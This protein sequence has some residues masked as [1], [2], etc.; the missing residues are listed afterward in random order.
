[1]PEVPDTIQEMEQILPGGSSPDLRLNLQ[2]STLH[3]ELNRPH[4]GN[5]LRSVDCARL[6]TLI[7]HLGTAEV[8]S[9]RAVLLSGEGRHFCTGGDLE[10]AGA[11]SSPRIGHLQRSLRRGAA[12]LVQSLWDCPLPVVAAVN[13]RAMG[14]GLHVALA[15]DFIFAAGSARLSEPFSQR[16]FAV[17]SGGSLLLPLR[18]G[19]ARATDMLMRGGIVDAATAARWGLVTEV[20][21]GDDAVQVARQRADELAAGPTVA[22]GETK[23]LM[24]SAASAQLA[25]AMDREARSVELTIRS[26]D[27]KEG[28]AAFG[29]KRQPQFTGS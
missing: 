25:A 13:G 5:A 1:M 22:I 3:I 9:V 27:F 7:D 23:Q 29:E 19:L 24:R 15:S 16:G 18:I 21:P 20:V 28:I 8:P 6:A 12:R 14:L 26:R 4:R 17:D 11:Q 10:A 2:G